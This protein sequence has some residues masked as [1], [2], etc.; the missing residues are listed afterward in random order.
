MNAQHL[1]FMPAAMAL[2]AAWAIEACDRQQEDRTVGQK[3]DSTIA[4]AE[5]KA[6]QAAAEMK[7]EFDAARAN[8]GP[9]IDSTGNKVRDAAITTSINAELARDSSL[10]AL[11]IDVDT[12]AGHVALRGAAPDVAARDRATRLA[13]RVDGVISVD[14]QLEIRK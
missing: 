8:A 7:K 13:Q 2:A 5:Q 3:I 10:S 6:N 14:N 12:S 4:K 9:A 1:P 11:K